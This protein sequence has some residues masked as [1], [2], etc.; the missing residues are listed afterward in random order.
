MPK[1]KAAVEVKQEGDFK[2]KSKPKKPK[3]LGKKND[4]PVKVDFT[5]PEAQGEVIPDIVKVDLTEKPK[6]DAIRNRKTEKV[7]V[8]EQ[9]GDSKG[10]DG[11]VRVDT[12]KEETVSTPDTDSPITEIIEEIVDTP[13]N[14]EPKTEVKTP[15]KQERQL[16]ENIDKLV[17]FM[18]ETGGT[19][20]D[21]VKIN[22]DYT[23]IDDGTL[24]KEYY[25][26]SKPH[27][28]NDEINFLIEDKFDIDEELDT[29]KDTRRKKLAY[30]EEVAT[31]KTNLE[32][33]KTQYYADIK[34][35]P[36]VNAEQQK[37]VDFFDRYNKQ[38]KTVKSNQDYFRTQTNDLFNDEFKGFEYSLG[39]KKFRY[40]VQDP[41]A[42]AEKQ[43]NINNFIGKFTDEEGKISDPQGYH[44]A[45]Y[46]AMNADKLASHFYEQGKA[47]GIKNVVKNSKN[48]GT[49]A[50]RQVASGDVFVDGLKVKAISGTDSSKLKIRRR[51]FNN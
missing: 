11:Q 42:I 5:K 2:L 37:A 25:K 14:K 4:N 32:R 51:T 20:E 23:D 50:P 15:V 31:A 1:N 36:G 40:K 47:D 22:K 29:E 21:Y 3:N 17:K 45:L 9:T 16:P 44:K 13:K 34:N 18:D 6:E 12:P 10:M 43:T 8:G 35:R 19:V 33:L 28:S 27:L 24:L 26:Q 30:K 7:D 39:D 38:Q 41:G 49:E 48:P 46:A